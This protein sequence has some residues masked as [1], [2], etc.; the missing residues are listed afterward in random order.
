[1]KRAITIVLAI[2]LIILSIPEN[3]FFFR[4]ASGDD[5]GYHS[6][7]TIVDDSSYGNIAWSGPSN[8][9]SSDDTYAIAKNIYSVPLDTHYLKATNFNFNIPSTSEIKGI[10]VEIERH[11]SLSTQQVTDVT[12]QL[13]K[14]GNPVGDNKAS[15]E[16]WGGSDT[17]KVYGG[18][19][20]LWGTTWSPSDINDTDFGVILSVRLPGQVS[21]Y[22]DHIRIKVYYESTVQIRFAGNLS[23]KGGP[24]YI[25]MREAQEELADDGYY[26]NDSCQHEDW[27]YINVTAPSGKTIHLHWYNATTDTWYNST[28]Y[29][30]T[31][32]GSAGSG[33]SYYEFNTS[34]YITITPGHKY[35][36]DVECE[37]NIIPWQKIGTG[38]KTTRRYVKLGCDYE[39]ISY[40][41]LYL[42]EADY[43]SD[44]TS[45][46]DVLHHD[47]AT[48]SATDTGYLK[49][50]IPTDVQYRY[51]A[52]FVKYW[53]ELDACSKFTLNNFYY[54]IWWNVRGGNKIFVRWGKSRG[55][56][57]AEEYI[58]S[59]TVYSS[60]AA[61]E[62]IYNR[63][64]YWLNAGKFEV[65]QTDFTDNEIWEFYLLLVCDYLHEETYPRIIS[66]NSFISF[67]ILNLPDNTTLQSMDSDSDGLNDYYELFTSYTN[68]FDI[69][70]D[71]DGAYD[72]FEVNQNTDP[73]NYSDY[74][75]NFAPYA[76]NP[77]PANNSENVSIQ[78]LCSVKVYD[79][80]TSALTV[81]FYENTTGSWVLRQTNLSVTSG[82]RVYWNYTQATQ[83]ETAYWWKVEV[84][85]GTYT[86]TFIYKFTTVPVA[87]QPPELLNPSVEPSSGVADYTIFYFNVTW[88]DADGDTPADG[89]LKVNISKTG[90]YV[91]A[92]LSYVSGD[93]T[94]GALY[95]YSC[96][97]SAGE[98]NYQF[99]AYDGINYNHTS[100]YSGPS[101]EAQDLSFTIYTSSG[102]N[103]INFTAQVTP[104]QGLTTCYN[105][106]AEG[107]DDTTPALKVEN[108]GNVPL[109]FTW[110][111]TADLPSGIT[112][113]YNYSNNPPN[114]GENLITT[115]EYQ[116]ATS[117]PVGGSNSTWMWMD[118][119]EVYGGSGERTL[120][121]NST[122]G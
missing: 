118:F 81:K 93:N 42:W 36:F 45:K 15:S 67:I 75:T 52:Q 84:T 30:F 83:G 4:T 40:I 114:P 104:G 7:G 46:D 48:G 53:L 98:Y 74:P 63:I 12:V 3:N 24:K 33:K 110:R 2:L 78:P 60:D 41:P 89:Y 6:P 20:D 14:N 32:T 119:V 101:V 25:P 21:A 95:S 22:V 19:T 112:L 17:Y 80:D 120:Q 9:G 61:S 105:V 44:D 59:T 91:N 11:Q 115:S 69:D 66:D 99:W 87:N 35:S 72:K 8:A 111:L 55:C 16:G 107:Q 108:T 109:N 23:D 1:V 26:T 70:T 77:I 122:L 116:F 39:N 58:D 51:C 68:P 54:H 29:V 31:E 85:D 121:V 82:S 50:E 94:T 106:S 28:S 73:N 76:Y 102:G 43:T 38:N 71:D 13:L 103:Y 62:I 57:S 65:T 113:K 117:V 47:Q 18:S 96:K 27:I 49:S 88:K 90:W 100:Q 97:L 79:K 64:K 92:S 37:N 86:S 5:T 34:D 10:V 56:I